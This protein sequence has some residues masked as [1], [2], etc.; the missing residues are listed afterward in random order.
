MLTVP[1]LVS[2]YIHHNGK[3]K[4]TQNNWQELLIE[5]LIFGF[6]ILVLDYGFMFV[7]YTQR[8]VSFVPIVPADSNVWNASF[9]FKYSF[10]ALVFAVALPMAYRVLALAK[11]RVGKIITD[12]LSEREDDKD[13]SLK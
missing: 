2:T 12:I 13:D 3:L 8:T 7:S 5:Y 6:I 9:V 11:K 10:A 1:G 4:V